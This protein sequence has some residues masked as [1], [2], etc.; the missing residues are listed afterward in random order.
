MKFEIFY[1]RTLV[2]ALLMAGTSCGH[3]PVVEDYANTASSSQE[4]ASFADDMTAANAQQVNVLSPQHFK[5]AQDAL[6]DAKRDQEHQKEA[7]VVLHRI[8]EGR[9]YLKQAN[10]VAGVAHQN[11]EEV[12]QARTQAITAGAP[13]FLS[14]ESRAADQELTNITSDIEKNDLNSAKKN[15]ADLQAKYMVLELSAI[16]HTQLAEARNTI[17]VAVK[18]G[19]RN[20]APRSLALAEK[21]VSDADAYI[22]A[23][24]HENEKIKEFSASAL[25]NANHLLKITRESKMN[26]KAAPEELAL[27]IEGEQNKLDNEKNKEKDGPKYWN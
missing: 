25:A 9:V 8:A 2:L 15:S 17:V 3:A 18:E 16:K 11:I 21:T 20:F 10:A 24:R 7:K 4:L 1:K 23:N 19:A 14:V 6:N 26:N 5:Q 27:Q 13:G 22:T 12:I